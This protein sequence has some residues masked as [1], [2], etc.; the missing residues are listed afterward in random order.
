MCG[1]SDV[2]TCV[3]RL[4]ITHTFIRRNNDDNKNNKQSEHDVFV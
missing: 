3:P 1:N 4:F 2:L